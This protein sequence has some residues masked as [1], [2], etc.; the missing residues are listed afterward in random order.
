MGVALKQQ[1]FDGQSSECVQ[2]R[3]VCSEPLQEEGA[4]Q[5]LEAPEDT[6]LRPSSQR[7]LKE[8]EH[9]FGER[10]CSGDCSGSENKKISFAIINSVTEL[11]IYLDPYVISDKAAR[12]CGI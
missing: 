10:K 7:E 5:C 9:S 4:R 11:S 8:T 6:S 3:P 12:V 2:R 1:R